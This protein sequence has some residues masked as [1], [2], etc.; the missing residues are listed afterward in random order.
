MLHF[1][2]CLSDIC[3]VKVLSRHQVRCSA[4]WNTHTIL[5]LE[6]LKSPSHIYFTIYFII[7]LYKIQL[8]MMRSQL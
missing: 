2:E 6:Y 1:V 7:I 8:L 3:H 5:F 4:N